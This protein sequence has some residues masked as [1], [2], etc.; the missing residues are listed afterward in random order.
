M[1]IW[2]IGLSGSGKTTLG[3]ALTARWRATAPNTVLVDGDEVRRL[4]AHD[5]SDTAYSLAGRR[6]NAERVTALC[7]W[8]DGQ[9]INVVCCLLS[10]FPEMRAGNRQRFSRYFEVYLKAPI[11]ALAAR[12]TK[13][14]YGPA[15]RGERRQVAGVDLPFPEPTAPDLTI[16]TAGPLPD[17]GQLA[18]EVLRKAGSAA[19]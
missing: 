13:D 8:L 19:S 16:D 12:D 7:A 11:E 15:L 2:I 17:I 3:R 1:V 5:R 14:L 9:G 18:D 10:L 6:L 4:F